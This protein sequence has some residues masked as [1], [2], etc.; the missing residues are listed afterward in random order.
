MKK[1]AQFSK[2]SKDRFIRDVKNFFGLDD[3]ADELLAEAYEKISLPYRATKGSAGYDFAIPFATSLKPGE[4]II[5][6]TGIR[7]WMMPG[8]VMLIY[9]RSSLGFKYHMT[10]ANTIPVIDED[11]FS[12]EN[13]GHI[14]IKIRND[15]S[16]QLDLTEGDRFAQGIFFDYGITVDDEVTNK[17]KGG[18][19]S[20][21]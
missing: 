1:V 12:A 6:P 8:K 18:I 2:V 19:G 4:E 7:C 5:V 9:P 16:K 10:I 15:G 11:Y 3:K 14:M 17:R 21:N 20:T 13:E